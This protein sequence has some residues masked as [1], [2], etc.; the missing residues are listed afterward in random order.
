MLH[1]ESTAAAANCDDALAVPVRGARKGG[2]GRLIIVEYMLCRAVVDW[3]KRPC[4]RRVESRHRRARF[5]QR[6][7]SVRGDERVF[8]ATRVN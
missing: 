7:G 3:C 5:M 4:E 2:V 1:E 6:F 8:R